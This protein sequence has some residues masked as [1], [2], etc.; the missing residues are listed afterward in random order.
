MTSTQAVTSEKKEEQKRPKRK[1]M[2]AKIGPYSKR[3][4]ASKHTEEVEE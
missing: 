1:K 2:V 4:K 3:L